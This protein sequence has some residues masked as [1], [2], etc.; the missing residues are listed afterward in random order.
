MA[1][2]WCIFYGLE[3][4]K[5]RGFQKLE[6]ES[7]SFVGVSMIMGRFEIST[8]C[9]FLVQKVR[10]TLQDFDSVVVWHVLQQ[11]FSP[12]LLITFLEE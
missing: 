6:V 9:R 3:L 8:N 7:D 11:I 10:D 2:I 5:A 4:A 12:I 1:E